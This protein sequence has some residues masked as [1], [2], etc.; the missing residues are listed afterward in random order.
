MPDPADQRQIAMDPRTAYQVTHMLEGVVLRGTAR[1]L[2]PLGVP[3]AGKTGTTTGPRDVWFVGGTP[4]FVAGLY[5]GYDTPQNLGGWMQGG[6][7]AAP[8]WKAFYQDAFKNEPQPDDPF[9][10]PPGIRMVRIDRRSGRR[11][12][13][14]WPTDAALAPVI[15]EAFKP[16]SEPRRI[17]RPTVESLEGEAGAPVHTDSDFLRNAGGIY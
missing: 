15:W 2:A 9:V 11:V 12:Y 5:V 17:A 6:T 10:A 3:I 14:V 4:H 7:F 8:I 16:D 1:T 13:G